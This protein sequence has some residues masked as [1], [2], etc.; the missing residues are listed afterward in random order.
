MLLASQAYLVVLTSGCLFVFF[1]ERTHLLKSF[2]A[3]RIV[4]LYNRVGQVLVEYEILHHNAW[5]QTV[6]QCKAGELLLKRGSFRPR[7]GAVFCLLESWYVSSLWK[8]STRRP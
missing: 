6:E 4:K 8:T 2:E 1:Q 7:Q 5:S 3:R